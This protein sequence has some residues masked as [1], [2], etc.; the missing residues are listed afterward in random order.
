MQHFTSNRLIRFGHDWDWLGAD[1]FMQRAVAL[2]PANSG[3]LITAATIASS[4]G[5]QDDAI[6]LGRRAIAAD[7]LNAQAHR[8]VGLFSYRAGLLAQAEE[9]LNESLELSPE[10]GLAHHCMGMT[11]VA[12]GRAAE[13]VEEVRKESVEAFR[14]LGEAVAYRASGQETQSAAALD[15]LGNLPPHRYLH[16]LGRAYRGEIDEAFASLE[17]A[18]AQGN[19]GLGAMKSEPLLRELHADPRWRAFLK[20]MRLDD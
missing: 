5:R 14:L 18:Y 15:A 1:A 4:S 7:P 16:A 11:H 6:A 20:K 3:V 13:A 9:A 12:Q 8:Y 10:S 17:R 19:A 2:A